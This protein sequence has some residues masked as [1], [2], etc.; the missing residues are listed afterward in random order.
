MTTCWKICAWCAGDAKNAH[1]AAMDGAADR[2]RLFRAD[3][4]DYGSVAAA[5]AGC[6]GFFHVVSFVAAVMVNPGW[7]QNEVMDEASWSDIE[8]YRTTQVTAKENGEIERRKWLYS[9][10]ATIDD[11]TLQELNVLTSL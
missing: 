5:I 10:H 8:F 2:L 6:D 4:L 7:P 9:S 1:L 11:N 3:L